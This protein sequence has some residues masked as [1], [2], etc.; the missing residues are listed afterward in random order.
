MSQYNALTFP[1]YTEMIERDVKKGKGIFFKS[2]RRKVNP[3]MTLYLYGKCGNLK[4][5]SLKN[6][7]SP[8]LNSQ[9][10]HISNPAFFWIVPS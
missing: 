9:Y 5:I 1:L 8:N 4:D 2:G 7:Q 3:G 6:L 10:Y